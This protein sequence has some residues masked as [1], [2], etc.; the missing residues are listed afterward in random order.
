MVV[1]TV[2]WRSDEPAIVENVPAQVC[3]SCMEQF[4]DDHV[5]EALRKIAEGTFEAAAASRVIAVPVYSLA[6]PPQARRSLPDDCYV[7]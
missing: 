4:Y 5:S 1:R 2:L 3:E 6:P 7:D